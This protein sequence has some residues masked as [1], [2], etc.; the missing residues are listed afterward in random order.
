MENL[1]GQELQIIK[2]ENTRDRRENLRHRTY[3]RKY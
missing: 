3:H 1:R 2:K